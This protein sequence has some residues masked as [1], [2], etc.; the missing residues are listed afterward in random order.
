[1]TGLELVAVSKRF[2]GLIA[3]DGVSMVVPP[4]QITG[5]IG[6]NGAGKT[7]LV[8]LITGMLPVTSGRILFDGRDLT[9]APAQ[10]I[11]RAGLARTFQNIRLM[12][13]AS[14]LANVM[15]GFHRHET[16]G[17]ISALLRLP[18]AVH[19][20]H[21]TRQKALALLERFGMA[22]FADFPARGLSYGHQRRVEVMR[23]LAT[24]PK[25]ILLDEPV[26]G[27]NDVESA[28]MAHVFRALAEEGRA[29]L[30]IEHDMRFV[31]HSCDQIYVLDG[32][33]LIAE[34]PPHRVLNLP[35]VI[36]AYL[37]EPLD[38]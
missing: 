22:A 4:G 18:K 13:D 20:T 9:D 21:Q 2:G 10:E 36:E 27:M 32:G 15:I 19:E 16:S 34:G 26:A 31:A 7:T 33:K 30:L 8:N 12:P 17:L 23:A 25:V 14:V 5:L 28:E 24:D 6:P 29:V 1:M 38:A 37:G 3:V 35:A 11:A